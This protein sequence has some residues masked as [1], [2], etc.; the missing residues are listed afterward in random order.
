MTSTNNN[1]QTSF[2]GLL[3]T[4]S[5]NLPPLSSVTL[6]LPNPPT[7]LP[8][9]PL[10]SFTNLNP[11]NYVN[12]NS[13]PLLPD[14]VWDPEPNDNFS[15]YNSN[16]PE[17]LDPLRTIPFPIKTITFNINGV[18]SNNYQEKLRALKYTIQA[19]KAQIILLQE[20]H[21][22]ATTEC[23]I[24][25]KLTHH[26]WFFNSGTNNARGVAIGIS[27]NFTA[28]ITMTDMHGTFICVDALIKGVTISIASIYNHR[29]TPT[30][31]N[32]NTFLGLFP[33][34]NHPW[35]WGGDLNSDP[36]DPNFQNWNTILLKTNTN[37]IQNPYPTMARSKRTID[38][39]A[40]PN[41]LFAN[42]VP[43]I[44]SL[45][46]PCNDHCPVVGGTRNCPDNH[47]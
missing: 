25:S 14:G 6:P 29:L 32:I 3:P 42:K 19:N 44:Y 24:I 31:I 18:R 7:P 9:P 8:Q 39:I 38:H 34:N 41:S 17:P 47:P 2:P 10:P 36:T 5:I 16:L 40:Y 1:M 46:P 37:F 28:S 43:F 22:Q 13:N 33:N 27:K 35:I 4:F 21:L 12:L 23:L 26:H 20:T 15:L 11:H 45:P 30:S